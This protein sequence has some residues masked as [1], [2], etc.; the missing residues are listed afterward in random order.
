MS[1]EYQFHMIV[2]YLA[3]VHRLTGQLLDGLGVSADPSQ[4]PQ[5]TMIATDKLTPGEEST[6][7]GRSSSH[8]T[9]PEAV[10]IL[11]R[12]NKQ[13]LSSEAIIARVGPCIRTRARSRC[14]A[15]LDAIGILMREGLIYRSGDLYFPS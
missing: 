4:L 7:D 13:G 15:V 3:D 8:V 6:L 1:N 5:P 12:N 10:L 14:R 11:L 2:K 9:H